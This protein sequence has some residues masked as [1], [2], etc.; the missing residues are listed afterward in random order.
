MSGIDLDVVHV[1]AVEI[2][3]GAPTHDGSIDRQSNQP[4]QAETRGQSSHGENN[5]AETEAIEAE[6]FDANLYLQLYFRCCED[7]VKYISLKKHP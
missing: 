3:C 4:H 5:R 6:D 2:E 7:P 1:R